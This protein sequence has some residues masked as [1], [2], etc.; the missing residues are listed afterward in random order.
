[1]K[2]NP[3]IL[4]AGSSSRFLAPPSEQSSTLGRSAPFLSPPTGRMN[5]K[6][7]TLRATPFTETPS[8]T[9]LAIPFGTPSGNHLG[10]PSSLS[11][12]DKAPPP[13]RASTESES[14]TTWNS[15]FRMANPISSSSP[16]DASSSSLSGFSS[17]FFLPRS[18][19]VI[20]PAPAAATEMTSSNQ[21]KPGRL[22]MTLLRKKYDQPT[23]MS[24]MARL[25]GQNN[26]KPVAKP[27]SHFS[28]VVSTPLNN[29]TRLTAPS[30]QN[31]ENSP[32]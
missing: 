20:D 7:S 22:R 27:A 1:M 24:F 2:G 32:V 10:S 9:P 3:P 31:E 15:L 28:S 19:P 30:L 11:A 23:P 18:T 6:S 29:S 17:F 14:S 5:G 16:S 12:A 21:N 25:A 8:S 26:N 13:P 4:E